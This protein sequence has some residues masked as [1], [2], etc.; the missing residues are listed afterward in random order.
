MVTFTP[1]HCPPSSPRD[2]FD[3]A[4]CPEL[5]VLYIL[6]PTSPQTWLPRALAETEF[7]RIRVVESPSLSLSLERLRETSFDIVLLD[8]DATPRPAH[9]VIPA[10]RCSAHDFQAILVLGES[11]DLPRAADYLAAGA[12]GYLSL[13]LTTASELVWQMVLAAERSQLLAE[14]EQL[15]AWQR[16]HE[17]H[18][19]EEILSLLEE[20][21]SVFAISARLREHRVDP[22]LTASPAVVDSLVTACRELLQAYVVMGRGH[23]AAEVRQLAQQLHA[24][25]IPLA[26][27]LHRFA[28]AMQGLIKVRGA[29]S[30]RHIYDRGNLLLLDLL[31][32][33]ADPLTQKDTP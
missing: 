10:I 29:R 28:Q 1:D 25:H 7:S 30:S 8:Q 24:S 14:N 19:Q 23:L 17:E 22:P 13:R 6:G 3:R 2:E 5:Q 11:D 20:Q 16:R 27:L 21:T 18:Q 32:Q 12:T 33:W 15:R 26:E 4:E 31:L 9:E